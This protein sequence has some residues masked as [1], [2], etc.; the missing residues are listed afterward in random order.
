MKILVTGAVGKLGSVVCASLTIYGVV[1]NTRG[2]AS[3]YD[4]IN[5]YNDG[6]EAE[7]FVPAL[8]GGT[9]PGEEGE[10]LPEEAP[11]EEPAP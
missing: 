9:P 1:E 8:P 3:L 5:I 2:Q 4:A 10:P 11:P 7:P 6:L